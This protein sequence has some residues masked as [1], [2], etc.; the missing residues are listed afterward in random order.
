MDAR[1]KAMWVAALNAKSYQQGAGCLKSE[2]GKFCSLGVL[3]DLYAREKEVPWGPG[4]DYP[5]LAGEEWYLPDAVIKWAGLDRA[6]PVVGGHNLTAWNDGSPD[7]SR[8]SFP[9]IAELIEDE[10]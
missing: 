8:V 1:V 2:D 6:N 7:V 10:L 9:R 3:T 5:A 4:E